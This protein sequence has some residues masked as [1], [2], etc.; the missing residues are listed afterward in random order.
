MTMADLTASKPELKVVIDQVGTPTYAYDLAHLITYIIEDS[1]LD[2]TGVYQPLTR[3]LSSFFQFSLSSEYSLRQRRF[4]F[5][6]MVDT[7]Q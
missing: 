7:S 4:L 2:R 3:P 5:L 6:V 1:L